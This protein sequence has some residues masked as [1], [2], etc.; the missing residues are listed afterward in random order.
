LFSASAAAIIFDSNISF[1][2]LNFQQ[3]QQQTTTLKIKET[4][5]LLARHLSS[6][7]RLPRKL[8]VLRNL[9]LFLYNSLVAGK[10]P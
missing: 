6:F 2:G 10:L 8:L 4:W 1:S 7:T 9:Y 5:I 3:N